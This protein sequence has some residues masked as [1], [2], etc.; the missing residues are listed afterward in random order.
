MRDIL[1]PP[2]PF[3]RLIPRS[4][5]TVGSAQSLPFGNIKH[6][7]STQDAQPSSDSGGIIVMVTGALQVSRGQ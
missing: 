4:P 6:Q 5:D 3:L 7:V 1:F 2:Y